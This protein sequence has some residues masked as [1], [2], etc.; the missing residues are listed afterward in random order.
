[1]ATV[2]GAALAL[3]T[4]CSSV[5]ATN[6]FN[7]VGIGVKGEAVAQI[8]GYISGFYLFGFMP[9]WSGSAT[10]PGQPVFFSN[11]VKLG[12]AISMI[13]EKSKA[14]GAKRLENVTTRMDFHPAIPIF[15]AFIIGIKE[16]QVSATGVK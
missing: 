7:G 10:D 11:N 14:M 15:P 3:A 4:G 5:R 6:N 16:C 1:M 13:T 2:C 12:N 8:N 9:F